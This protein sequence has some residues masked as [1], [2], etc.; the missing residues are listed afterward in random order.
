MQI[1]GDADG[2]LDDAQKARDYWTRLNTCKSTT[3]A[4]AP[5]PCVAYDGCNT[6]RPEIYCEIP[7]MGH[8]LWA[9][10]PKATWTFIK[11]R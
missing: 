10:A 6:A 1:I 3:S 9:S 5:S 8:T 7:G 11:S 4:F 2:L